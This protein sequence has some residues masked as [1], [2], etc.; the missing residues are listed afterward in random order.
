MSLDIDTRSVD[1]NV[2]EIPFCRTV[3][4]PRAQAAAVDVLRSGW[5]TMG[6]ETIA[7][8]SEL[9]AWLDTPEVIAVS[10]CTAAIQMALMALRLP[11]GSPVLTPTLTFSG[12]V[13]AILHA[14]LRPVFVDVDETS[15]GVSPEGV[16]RA[17]RGGVRAMVVQHMAGFPL[18]AV[19]LATAAGIG[20]DYVVE[21]AAHGLGSTIR[22]EA[23]GSRSQAACFSFYATKNL[24]VGEGGAVATTDPDL[25]RRLRAMRLHGMTQDA[26]RRYE[27]SGTWKY[28]VEDIGLKANFTDVQAAIGRAQLRELGG[29]QGRRAEIAAR[30][31]TQLRGIEGLQLPPVPTCG[32]HAWH[33]YAIQIHE[34]FGWSR[35]E[36]VA[37]LVKWGI[38][39]SVHFIPV[40]HLP[41]FRVTLGS[42]ACSSLPIA[43]AVFSRLLSLPLYPSMSD[44]DV[45]RVCD[46]LEYLSHHTS[47]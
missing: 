43:D 42:D 29:W 19:E 35:D 11:T 44:D 9:A 33:L 6:R 10:S 3:I 23:I 25:A 27:L 14:G 24:P 21:D 2:R 37:E 32:T 12:A 41:Y 1:R 18:D 34:A 8:E 15:L 22:G 30:Y 39:T 47:N 46:V 31:E 4:T 5:V 13:Q 26:W 38:G 36:T 40:H 7:F 17:A 28:T 20:S 16:A 45:D